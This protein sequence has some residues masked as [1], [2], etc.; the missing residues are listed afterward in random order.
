[1]SNLYCKFWKSVGALEQLLYILDL[2]GSDVIHFAD[3][4]MLHEMIERVD[5]SSNSL[6]LRDVYESQQ[7]CLVVLKEFCVD[8]FSFTVDEDFEIQIGNTITTF[9]DV[10]KQCLANINSVVC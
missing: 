2:W 3:Y 8:E 6:L 9:I 5:C 4:Q 1:M 10:I 7:N